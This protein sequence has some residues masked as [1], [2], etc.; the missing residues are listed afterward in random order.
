MKATF[1]RAQKGNIAMRNPRTTP[2]RQDDGNL[3]GIDHPHFSAGP[4]GEPAATRES[5]ATSVI[6]RPRDLALAVRR[7]LLAQ[8]GLRFSSL[9][10]RPVPDGVCLEGTLVC[11]SDDESPDIC[12]VVRRVAGVNAVLNHLVTHTPPRT[13][14]KG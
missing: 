11:D 12:D 1:R 2:T 3:R 9:V 8:E 6:D 13:P 4:A 10:V 7:E 5:A 14:R